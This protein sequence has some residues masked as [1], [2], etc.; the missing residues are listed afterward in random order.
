MFIKRL[1]S[2]WHI[3]SKTTDFLFMWS[4]FSVSLLHFKAALPVQHL[5]VFNSVSISVLSSVSSR[6]VFF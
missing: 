6:R 4:G 3:M 5:L 1:V 2:V